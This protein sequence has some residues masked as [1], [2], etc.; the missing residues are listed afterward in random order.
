MFAFRFGTSIDMEMIAGPAAIPP[1]A[2]GY[3]QVPAA[4]L[5]VQVLCWNTHNVANDL[6][7]GQGTR[8]PMRRTFPEHYDEE[9]YDDFAD[10]KREFGSHDPRRVSRP[11]TGV[12]EETEATVGCRHLYKWPMRSHR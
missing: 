5:E 3:K 8:G 4:V 1:G 6:D 9:W 12:P 10:A 11:P 2:I 7:L